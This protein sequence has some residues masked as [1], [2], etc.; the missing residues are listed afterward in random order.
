MF[1]FASTSKKPGRS[2]AIKT[3]CQKLDDFEEQQHAIRQTVKKIVDTIN[4]ADGWTI[5]GWHRQGTKSTADDAEEVLANRTAGH[6]SCLMPTNPANLDTC[7]K[8]NPNPAAADTG[9][10]ADPLNQDNQHN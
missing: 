6:I 7:T 9:P 3:G 8:H 2:R 10:A 5:I 4:A 1:L